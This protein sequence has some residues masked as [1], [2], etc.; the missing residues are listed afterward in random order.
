L[1]SAEEQDAESLVDAAANF[2]VA[3]YG[4]AKDHFHA[5]ISPKDR[6]LYML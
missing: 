4:Q 1:R 6:D 5:E 2:L 3:N